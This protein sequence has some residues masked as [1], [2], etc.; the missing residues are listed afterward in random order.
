MY[1]HHP[2]TKALREMGAFQRPPT[3]AMLDA[4]ECK[5][6]EM[7]DAVLNDAGQF[8]MDTIR[9]DAVAAVQQWVYT[10]DLDV[11]SGETLADRLSAYLVGIAD[12]NKDGEITDDE[13]DVVNIA[14]NAAADYLI[15]KGAAEEDVVALIEDGSADAADRIVGL[16]KDTLPTDENEAIA[17][18]DNFVFD[19][20]S[21]EDVLDSVIG[22]F[23]A[24][25]KKRLVIRGGRKIRI[26]KRVSGRV[27]LS[28]AQKV[29][30]RKARFKA[31]SAVA[32]MHRL[33]S[34]KIRSRMG[35]K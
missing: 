10:D 33:K 30:L 15:A 4:A 34:M 16:L 5:K 35:V 26:N 8:A 1:S 29:G 27:R 31:N 12:E 17:D 21:S 18:V 3:Q 14:A 24:V 19:A 28:A 2:A 32:K 6:K 11:T 22:I 23:D 9:S 25:Y 20:E 7:L 13:A